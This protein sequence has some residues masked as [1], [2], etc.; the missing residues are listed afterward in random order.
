[1]LWTGKI[2]QIEIATIATMTSAL[3]GAFKFFQFIGAAGA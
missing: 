2:A 1:L 3:N